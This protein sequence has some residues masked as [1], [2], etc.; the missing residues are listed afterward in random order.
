M[1]MTP[2]E[3]DWQ[4]C[5]QLLLQAGAEVTAAVLNAAANTRA[6]TRMRTALKMR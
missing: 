2:R 6:G 4:A 5:A 1:P 3:V